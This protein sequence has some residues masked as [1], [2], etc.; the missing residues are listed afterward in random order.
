MAK[1]HSRKPRQSPKRIDKAR[2]QTVIESRKYLE[3]RLYA[4]IGALAISHDLNKQVIISPPISTINKILKLNDLV[5][6][7][8]KYSPKGVNYPSLVNTL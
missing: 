6:K 5:H 7:R 4:Q 1:S 3:K 8:L 2:E